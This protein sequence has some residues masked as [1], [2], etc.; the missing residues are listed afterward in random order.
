[1]SAG[2][3]VDFEIG[4]NTL[5]S[6]MHVEYTED[7][8]EHYVPVETSE[9]LDA[10]WEIV[11]EHGNIEHITFRGVY[12][13]EPLELKVFKG[14]KQFM[15]VNC[16]VSAL[17]YSHMECSLLELTQCKIGFI[18]SRS[19]RSNGHIN[20]DQCVFFGT[21]EDTQ[22]AFQ[23]TLLDLRNTYISG[24]VF[25][26][27]ISFA[28]ELMEEA[29]DFLRI[30]HSNID[31]LLSL[32]DVTSFSKISIEATKV[33]KNLEFRRGNFSDELVIRG[34]TC[35]GDLKILNGKL[36]N[37]N[38]ASKVNFEISSSNI[39]GQL[40]M[41]DVESSVYI[42]VVSTT[43][44]K[45]VE[46]KRN[47][48]LNGLKFRNFS[49]GSD[50]EILNSEVSSELYYS[51]NLQHP[52]VSGSLL[53]KNVSVTGGIFVHSP[54]VGIN[55]H[56][57][58]VTAIS[59]ESGQKY[60]TKFYRGDISSYF[61]LEKCSFQGQFYI[62]S[63]NVGGDF[64]VSK[65]MFRSLNK[66]SMH[67]SEK[68]SLFAQNLCVRGSFNVMENNFDGPYSN[69]NSKIEGDLYFKF[70]KFSLSGVNY[71][72]DIKQGLL[73]NIGRVFLNKF[74]KF[75]Y[76]ILER[77]PKKRKRVGRPQSGPVVI[78]DFSN[79]T[80]YGALH[81]DET[82]IANNLTLYV[83]YDD[84]KC[85]RL[86]DYDNARSYRR[87]SYYASYEGFIYSELDEDYGAD[88][89]KRF[90]D[91]LNRF[92]CRGRYLQPSSMQPYSHL[93][94]LMEARG[95]Q[96]MADFTLIEMKRN[97]RRQLKNPVVKFF[98]F[99][100]DVLFGYGLSKTKATFTLAVWVAI[101]SL[102][103]NKA[104]EDKLFILDMP[105]VVSFVTLK[106]NGEFI[107]ANPLIA[108]DSANTDEI[109]C[110]H[111]IQS[112][113]YAIEIILPII[114]LGQEKQCILRL[115]PDDVVNNQTTITFWWAA[116]YIY[117]IVGWLL[118]SLAIVTYSGV[119][120]RKEKRA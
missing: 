115:K 92:G 61:I 89:Y 81:K 97:M 86:F 5:T 1:M 39:E 84:T 74:G 37:N 80:I 11:K 69:Y 88:D 38:H 21:T 4:F 19:L 2:E 63:S 53:I 76:N 15:F 65:S 24:H 85:L 22:K 20:I 54:K 82:K 100:F 27:E 55:V 33:G 105:K 93:S 31:G 13:S 119:V 40:K 41:D 67:D 7:S 62:T 111:D 120:R 108:S 60:S 46:L 16:V 3:Q 48:F 35:G 79:T 91:D 112:V 56:F 90:I 98:S 49:C 10:Y 99:F 57:Q 36:G 32:N 18:L 71:S 118:V 43:V 52:D 117:T 70:N 14:V 58:N 12:L 59:N 51:L 94:S 68:Y 44:G 42:S 64:R 30:S 34:L 50:F 109:D 83:R 116:R 26:S 17:D 8:G 102:G 47:K 75:I 96:E 28:E 78:A 104:I 73:K 77:N 25:L 66:Q 110:A 95:D 113:F 45:N 29:V 23:G 101:G 9:L 103:I 106:T 6:T 114:D 72:E 107:P 87:G